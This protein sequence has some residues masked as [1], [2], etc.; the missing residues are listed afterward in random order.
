MVPPP[1]FETSPVVTIAWTVFHL[2][3]LPQVEAVMANHDRV[4]LEEPPTPGFAEM[5]A[6]EM[7]IEAYLELTDF[8]FPAY[9]S[10]QCAM[11]R[12]LHERGVRILQVHPWLQEL[13]AVQEFFLAGGSPADLAPESPAAQ[14]YACERAWTEKLLAFYQAAGGNSFEAMVEA[15]IA[16]AKAD[17][18]KFEE[19]DTWRARAI[20]PLVASVGGR[21]YVEAGA[22]HWRLWQQLWRQG[23]R[24]RP[25]HV[26]GSTARSHVGRRLLAP[27]DL[28]T[29]RFLVGATPERA[30]ERLLAAR[31]L[32]YN[33]LIT[34]EELFPSPQVSFP[35][36]VQEAAILQ[37]LATLD[38]DTCRQLFF[39]LRHLSPAAAWEV[40]QREV[41]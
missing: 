40:L 14:V 27:G 24:P 31:T 6:G 29:L 12:R 39:R 13:V 38:F 16:F 8:E 17:A 2:E 26:L 37:R 23:V 22:L 1:R 34:K 3:T 9:Q 21:V 10:A 5:L 4:I 33:R 11:L 7:E 15:V 32:V 28:L 30:R 20:V 25:W 41:Q 18:A 35:H 19:Q 36:L